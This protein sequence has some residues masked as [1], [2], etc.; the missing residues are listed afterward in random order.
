M[1][2]VSFRKGWNYVGEDGNVV[3][4]NTGPCYGGWGSGREKFRTRVPKKAK[5]FEYPHIT[6]RWGLGSICVY[7]MRDCEEADKE[8]LEELMIWTRP[9]SSTRSRNLPVLTSDCHQLIKHSLQFLTLSN[10]LCTMN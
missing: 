9:T 4:T 6:K 10:I 2:D 7:I 3:Q 8:E 5:E 1:A